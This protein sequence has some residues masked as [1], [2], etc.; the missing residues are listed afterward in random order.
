[1]SVDLFGYMYTLSIP[2]I[3]ACIMAKY[4]FTPLKLTFDSLFEILVS[5]NSVRYWRV[6]YMMKL[7][8]MYCLYVSKKKKR[9]KGEDT[10][11]NC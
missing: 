6:R 7:C 2:N 4:D 1:M 9:K 11:E 5:C 8:I 10:K 3:D